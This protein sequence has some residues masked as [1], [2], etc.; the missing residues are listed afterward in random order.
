[1]YTSVR[2]VA[3]RDSAAN[4]CELYFHHKVDEP[5]EIPVWGQIL[6]GCH[7]PD[8]KGQFYSVS[9]RIKSG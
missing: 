7:D 4:V 9:P 3:I 2:H 1:M 5:I 6:Y 8:G